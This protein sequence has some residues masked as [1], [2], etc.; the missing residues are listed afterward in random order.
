[1]ISINIVPTTLLSRLLIPKF[2]SRKNKC[3]IINVT[4][5]AGVYPTPYFSV[6]CGTKAYGN[7]LTSCLAS[8]YPNIDILSFKPSE[9]STNMTANKPEDIMTISTSACV[10]GLFN[11]LGYTSST[12]GHWK[13]EV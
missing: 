11:E 4:S 7:F 8:E 12:Y 1:M 9:V 3:A 6:Y 13:H 5:L 2:I 10:E